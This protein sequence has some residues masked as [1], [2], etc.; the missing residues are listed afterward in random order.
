MICTIKMKRWRARQSEPEVMG[1]LGG[2]LRARRRGVS[3][4]AAGHRDMRRLTSKPSCAGLDVCS[5][6]FE[7]PTARV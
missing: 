4:G 5:A 2:V 7:G 6:S 1:R 3:G